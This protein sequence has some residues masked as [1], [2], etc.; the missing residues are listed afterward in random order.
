MTDSIDPT[1]PADIGEPSSFARALRGGAQT[2]LITLGFVALGAA[3]GW[4]SHAGLEDR[5]AAAAMSIAAIGPM[6]GE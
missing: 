1:D 4:L 3:L 5:S 2:L 6:T